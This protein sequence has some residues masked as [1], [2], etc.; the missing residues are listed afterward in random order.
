MRW[1]VVV[2]LG[3]ALGLAAAAADVLAG[4]LNQDDAWRA[5]SMLLNAGCVWAGLAVLG[6]WLLR[7]PGRGAIA[8]LL[9]LSCSLM[10][11][12]AGGLIYGDRAHVGL[13][14]LSGVIR[15]WT[16]AAVLAGPLLGGVGALIR[17]AGAPGLVAALVLPVG[18]VAEI[19]FLHRLASESFVIDPWLA[20]TQLV[21]IVTACAGAVLA[22]SRSLTSV[23]G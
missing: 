4:G 17:R 2:C 16:V 19:L 13:G 14:G 6:G 1:V 5:V 9:G 23:T 22:M 7:T 18:T 21:L 11:Y 20:W 10:G 12:Y 15:V 3:A 8:G